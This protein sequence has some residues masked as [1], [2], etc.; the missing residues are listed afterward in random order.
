[1]QNFINL[2][3]CLIQNTMNKNSL[4]FV[5]LF[6]FISINTYTQNTYSDFWKNVRVGGSFNIGFGN[7]FTTIAI[8]PSAIYDFNEYVSTGVSLT[9]LYHKNK[10]FNTNSSVYGA[11]ILSLFEPI[12]NFQLSAEFEELNI[13]R[14]TNFD[15]ENYWNPAFYVGAAYRTGPISI[16]LRY[17]LLYKDNKSIYN[18]AVSPVFRIYF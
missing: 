4:F 18:S 17:D 3:H 11:S 1:M 14:R 6:S 12:D 7:N 8:S 15:E 2:V 16:G 13:T 10:V 9:Y 5:L